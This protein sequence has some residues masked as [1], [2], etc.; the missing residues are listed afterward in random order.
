MSFKPSKNKI[1]IERV[2]E[3]SDVAKKAAQSGLVLTEALN[4]KR[5]TNRAIVTHV[6]YGP[7]VEQS[8]I[9]VGDTVYLSKY[10]GIPLRI[11]ERDL[12]M[13]SVDEILGHDT[14]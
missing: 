3:E 7:D 13:I 4:E 1:V 8:N 11:D 14:N 10:S 5:N 12:L 9:K 6:G 2:M